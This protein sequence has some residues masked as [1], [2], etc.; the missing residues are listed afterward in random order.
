MSGE[1]QRVKS[2]N[3]TKRDEPPIP[4]R[5]ETKDRR[6]AN[7][8]TTE[9]TGSSQMCGKYEE[10]EESHTKVRHRQYEYE[11]R[12]FRTG[13]VS[14]KNKAWKDPTTRRFQRKRDTEQN[15]SIPRTQLRRLTRD[16]EHGPKWFTS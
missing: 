13:R 15:G 11:N 4:I 9:G 14:M 10:R 2:D 7:D 1:S 3:G 8:T 12:G 6:D 5:Y 16:E